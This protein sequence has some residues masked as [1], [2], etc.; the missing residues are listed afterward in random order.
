MKRLL[1]ILLSVLSLTAMAQQKP[2]VA[3]YI[4][5]DNPVNE[6]IANRLM[7]GFVSSGKYMP[8]ERS[9]AFLAAVRKEQDYQRTGEVDDEQIA[10]LGVQ[11]GIQYICVV[12]KRS[13]VKTISHP[14]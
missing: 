5:G 1:I 2:K 10:R 9:A 3:I 8:V 13:G 4:I 7:S 6:I 11:F 14:E 12:S